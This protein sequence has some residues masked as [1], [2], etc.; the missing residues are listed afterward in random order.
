MDQY[1]SAGGIMGSHVS[2]GTNRPRVSVAYPDRHLRGPA[3]WQP[4]MAMLG[5]LV[6]L[7]LALTGAAIAQADRTPTT[8][9]ILIIY[10]NNS[11]LPAV[12]EASRGLNK[13]LRENLGDQYNLYTE[14]L[15]LVR[16]PSSE[17]ERLLT[18]GLALTYASIKL[19]VVIAAGEHALKFVLA[20]RD[21]FAPHVPVIFGAVRKE[22]LDTLALPPDVKGV[23]SHSDV[24][25]TLELARKLQPDTKNVVIITG[26]GPFDRHWEDIARRELGATPM[27]VRYISGLTLEGFEKAVRTLPPN[28]I[29]IVLTIYR[30]ASGR[31]ITPSYAAAQIAR[32]SAAP[33]Y[34][35]YDSAIGDGIVGGSV[36]PF[37]DLGRELGRLA[38]QSMDDFAA[39]PAITPAQPR[40]IVDWRQFKRWHIPTA[41]IPA[42]AEVRHRALSTFERYRWQF[43]AILSVLL[44]QAGTIAA[45]IIERRLRSKTQ[46][47][48]LEERLAL[49]HT[50]RVS[51]LGELSGAFAHELNQPL[52]SILANAEAGSKLLR[53]DN[54]DYAEVGD[55]MEDIITNT[56]RSADFI[57]NLRSLF[58]KSGVHTEKFELNS[59]IDSVL[60][61]TESAALTSGARISFKKE[62]K[63]LP[64]VASTVQIQHVVLNLVL[65]AID[66]MSTIAVP[67]RVIFIV[68]RLREDGFRELSVEDNGPGLSQEMMSKV[69]KPFVTTKAGGLGLGLAI[70]HTI[71]TAY[72]G[73][74]RFDENRRTGARIV[75]ALPPPPGRVS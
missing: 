13:F 75:L 23:V 52:T 68:S 55:I 72:G 26:S 46:K 62:K 22:T 33:V 15:D 45:L 24:L 34:S 8:K 50:A 74:L 30:D 37:D 28:T 47:E 29:V 11:T 42:D 67:E 70:C 69:F 71:V 17:R 59:V 66:A 38:L 25:K 41:R 3:G 44:L 73:T 39:I 10:G 35:V 7:F 61:L 31:Q 9:N 27:K 20:H 64:V 18:D 43:Y 32:A 36:E 56:N 58:S 14:Y 21:R 16:F 12:E 49:E 6:V 48:L 19:D 53:Q 1:A 40:S 2:D 65:N 54:P 5:L 51:Q 4:L 63:T 57:R 60:R